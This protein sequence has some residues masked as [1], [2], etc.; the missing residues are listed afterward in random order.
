[1]VCGHLFS[2]QLFP[3]WIRTSSENPN[4]SYCQTLGVSVKKKKQT[5]TTKKTVPEQL[6]KINNIKIIKKRTMDE[7]TKQLKWY[8]KTW[9]VVLLLFTLFP[10]GLYALWKN[11]LVST[12][13]KITTTILF[14]LAFIKYFIL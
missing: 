2:H 14:I 10:V 12:V 4:V 9:L 5:R 7:L 3:R 6:D 8:D 11:T 1:M 13:T